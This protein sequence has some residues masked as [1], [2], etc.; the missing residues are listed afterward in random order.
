[1]LP[2]YAPL[3]TEYQFKGHYF[4]KLPKL[5]EA[6]YYYVSLLKSTFDATN[7]KRFAVLKMA[8]IC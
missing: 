5:N 8:N 3:R 2:I 1:M 6:K 4:E 7:I